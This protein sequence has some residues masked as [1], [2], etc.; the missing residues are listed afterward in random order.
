MI[1]FKILTENF[2]YLKEDIKGLSPKEKD[3]LLSRLNRESQKMV[4]SFA[5]LV[6]R[7]ETCLQNNPCI[8]AENLKTFFTH[9]I[10]ELGKK[11]KSC[12]TIPQIMQKVF[13]GDYWSF[14][15]YELLKA[16]INRFCKGTS[17]I[18]E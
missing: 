13:K 15:N 4:Y 14:F 12:N 9:C 7:T 18:M 10:K 3:K 17:A 1:F 6:S 8:T 16:L 11:L 5:D 2:P